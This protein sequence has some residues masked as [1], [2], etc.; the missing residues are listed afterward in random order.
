MTFRLCRASLPSAHGADLEL[1]REHA[2]IAAPRRGDI[3]WD[4]FDRASYSAGA[5]AAAAAAWRER[6]RQEYASLA[7]F[8]QL[9]SQLHLLGTPLDW[10]GAFARMIAD[11]VRH[12]ELCARMA[13]TLEPNLA[14][15]IDEAELHL[16]VRDSSL[17]AHVRGA[18]LAASCIGETLSG[19]FFRRCLRATTVPLARDVVRTIV[20]DETFH[21]ELGWELLALLLRSEG[22]ASFAAERQALAAGLSELFEHYRA[23]CGAERGE[24]WARRGDEAP[25]DPNFGTLTAQGYARAFFDGMRKDVVPRLVAVGLPEAE[26]AWAMLSRD[27]DG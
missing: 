9:S 25:S 1:A 12:T 24:A 7:V 13:E 4:S 26:G 19:R 6:A 22:D 15:E 2:R 3:H 5:L 18:V 27:G 16:P 20:D 23:L 17:R 21:G 10:A 14:V 8:T 11:E